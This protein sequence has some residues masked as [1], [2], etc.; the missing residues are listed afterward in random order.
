M[1]NGF[2]RIYTLPLQICLAISPHFH[3][4]ATVFMLTY[5]YLI[6]RTRSDVLRFLPER[7]L[8]KG[9]FHD[10]VAQSASH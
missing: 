4:L 6:Y 1:F 2:L 10:P 3:V 5:L 9:D 8:A 7:L